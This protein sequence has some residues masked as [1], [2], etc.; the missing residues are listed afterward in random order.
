LVCDRIEKNPKREEKKMK[1][2]FGK[3]GTQGIEVVGLEKGIFYVP[4]KKIPLTILQRGEK[5]AIE[6]IKKEC[7]HSKERGDY[8]EDKNQ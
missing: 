7:S 3:K 1:W 5:A 6:W 4:Q 2:L 8:I